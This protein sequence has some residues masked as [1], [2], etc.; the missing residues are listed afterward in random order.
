MGDCGFL[1]TFW[2]KGSQKTLF[3]TLLTLSTKIDDR[4]Y[5]LFFYHII[6]DKKRN[7]T[8]LF[9][10]LLFFIVTFIKTK[11]FIMY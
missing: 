4:S 7:R 6:F 5:N 11:T 1:K 8:R 10:N 3:L 9:I 2:M